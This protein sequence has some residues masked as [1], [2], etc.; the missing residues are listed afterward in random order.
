MDPNK[1]QMSRYQTSADLNFTYDFDASL[2]VHPLSGEPKD[3]NPT[4]HGHLKN[5]STEG[6][7]FNSDHELHQGDVL[8]L[9]VHVPWTK[10]PVHLMAKVRWT[11]EI[12]SEDTHH[13]NTG[14]KI[15]TIEGKSVEQTIRFD[16]AHGIYWSEVLESIL[17]QYRIFIQQ[18]K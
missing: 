12:A 4:Y 17:G 1:R 6:L 9:D 14:V 7:C 11:K 18:Q 5:V 10:T 2:D 13:F 8:N 3:S 15:I 16:Q